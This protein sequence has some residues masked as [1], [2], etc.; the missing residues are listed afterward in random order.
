M[1]DQYRNEH[2]Q[3]LG[4]LTSGV[5]HELNTPLS[6]LRSNSKV[7]TEL[8][9]ELREAESDESRAELL[10]ECR[11][12]NFDAERGIE[13]LIDIV[14]AI[15]VFNKDQAELDTF[16]IRVPIEYAL[17]LVWNRFK[18]DVQVVTEFTENALVSG[19]LGQLVQVFVNLSVN[20]VQAMQ[21]VQEKR[22][23]ITTKVDDKTVLVVVS[24]N[25]PGIPSDKK[26]EVF[27]P[28]F[29]T[30]KDG[31]GTGLGLAIVA[32]IL[33][34]H[35]GSVAISDSVLGGATFELRFPLGGE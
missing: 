7:L 30:K 6:V 28:F 32:D 35:H 17:K 18:Y 26:D 8:L 11:Q 20:S 15:S 10:E 21:D 23:Q 34:K 5:A 4:L 2:L 27:Q 12:I 3:T 25:G 13:Q 29:T 33:A 9:E 19:Q 24:D 14:G 16:D 22:F 1:S 31:T